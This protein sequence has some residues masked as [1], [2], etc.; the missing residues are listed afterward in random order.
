MD[1]RKHDEQKEIIKEV[2]QE[3]L[4]KQFATFGKWTMKGFASMAFFVVMYF[5]LNGHG[6]DLKAMAI[7]QLQ[8][9]ATVHP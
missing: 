6:V 5:W 4:D 8:T 3:W 7:Q 1:R 9:A 2:M